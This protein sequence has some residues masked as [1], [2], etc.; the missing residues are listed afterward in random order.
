VRSGEHGFLP[1]AIAS[2][3]PNHIELAV[4]EH[5]A[6]ITDIAA[7]AISALK[8]QGP[9]PA[10]QARARKSCDYIAL[11]VRFRDHPIDGLVTELGRKL[12]S[13]S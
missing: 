11:N 2:I 12:T 10:R 6:R 3:N 13:R 9:S 8:L 4:A 1:T 5:G 7:V